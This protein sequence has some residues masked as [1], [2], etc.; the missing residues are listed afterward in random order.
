MP[1]DLGQK[2]TDYSNNVTKE[3]L[4]KFRNAISELA[5]T[6]AGENKAGVVSTYLTWR[7]LIHSAYFEVSEFNKIVGH[8]L[9]EQDGFKSTEL[10]TNDPDHIR[11]KQWLEKIKLV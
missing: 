4:A 8:V 9:G 5:L 7:E 3:S 2:I 11:A 1:Q 6:E 10:F